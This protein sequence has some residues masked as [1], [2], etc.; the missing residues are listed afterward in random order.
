M[1]HLYIF[2]HFS[3]FIVQISRATVHC[4]PNLFSKNDLEI[5]PVVLTLWNVNS[6]KIGDYFSWIFSFFILI[7]RFF[8]RKY[9]I[10]LSHKCQMPRRYMWPFFRA[11]FV[12]GTI[13]LHS[14]IQRFLQWPQKFN[15]T[16]LNQLIENQY[17]LNS[18]QACFHCYHKTSTI[19][20]NITSSC[21]LSCIYIS[22]II[23][24]PLLVGILF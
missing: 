4:F 13:V 9:T 6:K 23:T 14:C 21:I 1:R 19:R 11:L 18:T 12:L 5:E 15:E 2:D 24:K 8:L 16:K 17:K 7:H 3:S 10:F 22:N 20:G